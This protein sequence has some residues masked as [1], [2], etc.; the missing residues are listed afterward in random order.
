MM[1]TFNQTLL[2]KF[3]WQLKNERD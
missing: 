3:L 2:G 1:R